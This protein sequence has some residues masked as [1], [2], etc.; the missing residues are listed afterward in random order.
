MTN[1][2]RSPRSIVPRRPPTLRSQSTEHFIGWPF[3][4]SALNDRAHCYYWCRTVLDGLPQ[5]RH[6]QNRADTD[7]RVAWTDDNG[8]G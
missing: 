7:N 4:G 6:G 3:E 5:A 8:G 1:A 2:V